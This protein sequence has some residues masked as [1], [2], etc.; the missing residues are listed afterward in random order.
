MCHM[1]FS[2]RFVFGCQRIGTLATDIHT[3]FNDNHFNVDTDVGIS[4]YLTPDTVRGDC[5]NTYTKSIHL[6]AFDN[7]I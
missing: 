3:Y 4:L 6:M 2:F 5:Y 1:I 7:A